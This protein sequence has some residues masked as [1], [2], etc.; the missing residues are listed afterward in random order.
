MNAKV[1]V[2]NLN[3][4]T[5]D[6]VLQSFFETAGRVKSARVVMDRET[7][8][9]RGFAFVEFHDSSDAQKAINDLNDVELE[10]RPLRI[11]EATDKPRP[12][13][14]GRPYQGRP[15]NDSRS[16]SFAQET[17]SFDNNAPSYS[18]NDGGGRKPKRK[19]KRRRERNEYDY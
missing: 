10:G 19:Q 9:S 12:S 6:S 14:G 4:Q 11:R 15:Q 8:N 16:P 2:G 18:D 3:Y 1:Y 5:T 7:G 13:G 17:P